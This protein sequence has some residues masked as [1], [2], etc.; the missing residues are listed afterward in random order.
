MRG[1]N[2]METRV[3]FSVKFNM[4]YALPL[5][6]FPLYEF[7]LHTIEK[8]NGRPCKIDLVSIFAG[9]CLACQPK[10]GSV[11]QVLERQIIGAV[12][13]QIIGSR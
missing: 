6:E 3:V 7:P 9:S 8:N 10:S 11:L 13:S 12:V 5:H 2:D 4:D 1:H